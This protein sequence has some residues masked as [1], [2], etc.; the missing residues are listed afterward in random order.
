[1]VA[2]SIVGVAAVAHECEGAP[3]QPVRRRRGLPG[4][5]WIQCLEL[6]RDR[7]RRHLLGHPIAGD[8]ALPDFVPGAGNFGLKHR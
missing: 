6:A 4:R 7:R 8:P 2:V 5:G 3:L 1:M